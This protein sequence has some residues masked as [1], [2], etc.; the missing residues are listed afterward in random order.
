M[1][2]LTTIATLA[3]VMILSACSREGSNPAPPRDDTPIKIAERA[4]T[5]T[6]PI[7]ASI[8]ALETQLNEKIPTR[9]LD[10]NENR[11]ACVPA[12]MAR[13]CLGISIGGRCRGQE[14]TTKI[15]P[16]IDC[17]LDG[18]ADRGAI[19]LSGSG[20]TIT[21]A[22][23]VSVDVK[24]TG[25]GEIGKNIQ[26]TVTGAATVKGSITPD[27]G[28]NWEPK[29]VIGINYDWTDRIGVDVLGQR[30]TFASRVDPKINEAIKKMSDELPAA[31]ASLRA[32]EQIEAVWKQSTK[33][34]KLS[35]D[36]ESWFRFT[37]QQA[38]FS[39]VN[40][41][42][43]VAAATLMIAG[44]TET[45][46]GTEPPQIAAPPLSPL[47]KAVPDP[48]F[49]LFVPVLADY[50]AMAAAAEKAL[51][52]GQPQTLN[53]P[54]LGKAQVTF[55]DVDVYQAKGRV[56]AIGVSLNVDTDDSWRDI[57][58]TVWMTARPVF[59]NATKVLRVADVSVV[60]NTNNEVVDQL[61]RVINFGPVNKLI[62]SSLSYNFN[63]KWTKALAQANAAL[64]R[65]LGN[66]LVLRGAINQANVREASTS[67][68]GYYVVL[69]AEGAVEVDLPKP[70]S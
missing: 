62:R 2:Q 30:I 54:G 44:R 10:V 59:D 35:Q 28:E 5:I 23:P 36:P 19:S 31:L 52:V 68:V 1:R 51:K 13:V 70:K 50:N 53:I 69:E 43:G 64:S 65:D 8:L 48:G 4:S 58:G 6:V 16:D 32:R 34:V 29:A 25:R 49:R 42:D 33:P 20:N 3:T 56:M 26:E 12:R 57:N 14:V 22:M 7:T 47:Q 63:D 21:L 38:G 17:H 39:G 27:I 40:V 67:P 60:A 61:I 66:G 55:T 11:D 46:L 37:P 15:T 9:L 24:V 18:H 45:F 41:Q